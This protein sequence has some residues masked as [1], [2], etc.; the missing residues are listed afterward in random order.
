MGGYP[1]PKLEWLRGYTPVD[2]PQ[3]L[4]IP[5]L[6][7]SDHGMLLTCRA[8]MNITTTLRI[9]VEGKGDLEH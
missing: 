8:G 9:R 2:N 4:T 7:A 6:S 3:V 5:N 1:T